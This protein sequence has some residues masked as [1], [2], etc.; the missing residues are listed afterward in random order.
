MS[1]NI[2]SLAESY[3]AGDD[4]TFRN[5]EEMTTAEV[6]TVAENYIGC[7]ADDL[8]RNERQIALDHIDELY[9]FMREAFSR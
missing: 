4:P 3:Y 5:D 8:T 2:D 1:L 9:D 6:M 7:L